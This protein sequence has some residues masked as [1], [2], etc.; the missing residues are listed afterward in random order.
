MPGLLRRVQWT[1]LR[2]LATYLGGDERSLLRGPG[3]ELSEVREYQPGDDVRHIDWNITARNDR[4]Y[5][6]EAEVE[7]ALDVWLLLDVSTSVDWGTAECLKRDRAVEFAAVAAQLLGNHGNRI[8]AILFADKPRGFMPPASGRTH[9]VRLLGAIRDEPRQTRHAPTDLHAAL[10]RA[11]TVIRRRSL[12]VIV[13]D[14][15]VEGGWQDV[16]GELA[17]RHEVVAVRLS[18]PRESVLPDV[19]LVTL[20][21]PETGA[22]M[23]V[24]TRDRALRDRFEAAAVKQANDVSAAFARHGIDILTLSTGSAMLPAL[25]QF[26]QARRHR[27]AGAPAHVRAAHAARRGTSLEM[28]R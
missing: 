7:R 5:V 21:D 24:D 4:A 12:V 3:I 10:R 27:R 13:S 26:L 9:L 2:P 22:Q 17:Q 19:G 1:V 8:G 23:V 18:D 11:R 6:R 25:V 15:L 28:T 20:E 14:F 16:L